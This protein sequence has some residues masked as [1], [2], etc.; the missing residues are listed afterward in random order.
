M[1]P[2]ETGSEILTGRRTIDTHRDNPFPPWVEFVAQFVEHRPNRFFLVAS[3]KDQGDPTSGSRRSEAC[4]S[5][6]QRHILTIVVE[7]S[8]FNG[9][10]P[11]LQRPALVY[12]RLPSTR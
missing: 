4:F 9:F 11:S 5:A 2:G 3:G 6:R 8:E 7:T 10:G 12:R 1:F